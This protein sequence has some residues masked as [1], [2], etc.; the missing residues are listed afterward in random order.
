ARC[1]M[2]TGRFDV[3]ELKRQANAFEVIPISPKINAVDHDD[4][5]CLVP[6]TDPPQLELFGARTR[7]KK[8]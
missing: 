2:D 7:T 1:W 6:V 4:P 8:E 3:D 5:G